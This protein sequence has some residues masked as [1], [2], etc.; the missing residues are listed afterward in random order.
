MIKL[1]GFWFL[2]HFSPVIK[3]AKNP[4]FYVFY[5]RVGLNKTVK[6]KILLIL[7]EEIVTNITELKYFNPILKLNPKINKTNYCTVL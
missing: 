7:I 3:C 2:S 1:I 6:R 5:Y 4:Y